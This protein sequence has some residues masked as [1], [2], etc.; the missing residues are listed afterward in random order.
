[1]SIFTKNI[2]FPMIFLHYCAGSKYYT[3][4]SVSRYKTM[5]ENE[6]FYKRL[7]KSPFKLEC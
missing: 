7:M 6:C 5:N 2:A 3:E 4:R 1:M